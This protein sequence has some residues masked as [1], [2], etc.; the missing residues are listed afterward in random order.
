MRYLM[1]KINE[2]HCPKNHTC[3][4][5]RYCPTNAISQANPYSAPKI[6]DSKCIK[7][8]KCAKMCNV[9]EVDKNQ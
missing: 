8:N 4:I 6:D 3:P 1:I 5:I 9:F 2:K 7:C